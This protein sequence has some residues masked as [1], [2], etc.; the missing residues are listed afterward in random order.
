M[1]LNV[2][3]IT[4]CHLVAPDTSL[5]GV[6]TQASLEAVLAQACAQ[7]HPDA[8]IASGDL[9]HDAKCEV[10]QRFLHTVRNTTSAPLLCLPGNHDVLEQMQAAD[11]PL[12]PLT[13]PGWDIVALDSHE[14]DAPR[15]LVQDGDRLQTGSQIEQAQGEHVLLATHHPLVAINSPWLDKDRIKNAG[16]LVSWLA[17]RSARAGEPRLRAVVFGHA[18]QSIA[19]Y[20]ARIPVFGTPSTCFQFAPGSATFTVDTT[21]PGYRWLSLSPDGQIETQ[22]FTVDS[23]P[24]HIQLDS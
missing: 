10:Y 12:A 4:D 16:E 11:L 22:V 1:S 24:I 9:A 23:F 5:L 20:V 13:L 17:E 8:V 7:R 14:D 3:H 6:D 21:S 15:A 19:D 18:H 2:L